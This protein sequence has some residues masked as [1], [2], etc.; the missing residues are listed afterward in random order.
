MPVGIDKRRARR[1]ASFTVHSHTDGY[2]DYSGMHNRVGRG[3]SAPGVISL[4]GGQI[5]VPFDQRSCTTLKH[6]GLPLFEIREH[7]AFRR[8]SCHKHRVLVVLQPWYNIRII[9]CGRECGE[10][11]H[12]TFPCDYN[13]LLLSL[14]CKDRLSIHIDAYTVFIFPFRVV[15][16]YIY[17]F[18]CI[19]HHIIHKEQFLGEVARQR[20]QG[21]ID[22][23]SERAEIHANSWKILAHAA[24]A[25]LQYSRNT[26]ISHPSTGHDCVK[27][28]TRL[29]C[30]HGENQITHALYE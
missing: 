15:R 4:C 23:C 6:P 10:T 18:I 9:V 1:G 2:T 28:A 30:S 7:F 26:A 17:I 24:T 16:V 22:H 27:S 25:C 13:G 11:A 29:L 20:I 14:K 21:R 3:A 5:N 19:I 8:S 12:P